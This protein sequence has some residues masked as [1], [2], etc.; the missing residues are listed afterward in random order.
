VVAVF[1]VL[2]VVVACGVVGVEVDM[3]VVGSES[4]LES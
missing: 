3:V 2:V 4:F 1:A